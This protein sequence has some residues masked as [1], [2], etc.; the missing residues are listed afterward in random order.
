LLAQHCDDNRDFQ[1]NAL[2][3][4]KK[5]QGKDNSHY[6]Y[7]YDRISV[8]LTGKQKY[9]TQNVNGQ[10]DVS[11]QQVTELYEPESS[12]PLHWYHSNDPREQVA[13]AYD[14]KKGYIDIKFT[15]VMPLEFNDMVEVEFSR[16]DS[17]D[18]TGQGDA[19][20]VLGTV[21]QAFREYLKGYQPKI[22]LFAADGDS[23]NKVYQNLIK[24]FATGAGYKQFDTNKLSKKMQEKL[25]WTRGA[26]GSIMILTKMQ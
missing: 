23:R 13:R 1:K 25:T 20:R 14:R 6:K 22:L 9:G 2:S 16:N 12:F 15:P 19:A 8:G 10:Q 24:R 4:I 26:G 21:L 18:M 7:L 5:Y 17:Y 3:I 11:E